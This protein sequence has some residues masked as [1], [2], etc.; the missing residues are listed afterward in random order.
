MMLHDTQEVQWSSL[1]PALTHFFW[2]LFLVPCRLE[3]LFR[4]SP[5][6]AE[7]STPFINHSKHHPPSP[8]MSPQSS[9]K[10]KGNDRI[11]TSPSPM[12]NSNNITNNFSPKDRSI[13]RTL[14]M[15]KNSVTSPHEKVFLHIWQ[16]KPLL[17]LKKTK[18]RSSQAS[19]Y[20]SDLI[21]S[22][23]KMFH[24]CI[25]VASTFLQTCFQI[26]VR[27][28][29]ELSRCCLS[30]T[31][32]D[33]SNEHDD[34][35]DD[36]A[37][38]NAGLISTTSECDESFRSLLLVLG[39]TTMTTSN[40]ASLLLALFAR[41][42]PL[43]FSSLTT[44]ILDQMFSIKPSSS[45]PPP[46]ASNT[47]QHHHHATLSSDSV[48]L[49]N[50][51]RFAALS[52]VVA[53]C[54]QNSSVLLS[55]LLIAI[56]KNLSLPSS[57][58]QS[59]SKTQT[60]KQASHHHYDMKSSPSSSSPLTVC[61]GTFILAGHLMTLSCLSRGDREAVIQWVGDA[62]MRTSEHSEEGSLE[63]TTAGHARIFLSLSLCVYIYISPPF[64]INC[65]YVI[66]VKHGIICYCFTSVGINCIY[67]IYVKHGIICYCFTSV[68]I[69]TCFYPSIYLSKIYR[70]S[71]LK[72]SFK[73]RI[74][75]CSAIGGQ[76][77]GAT[78]FL[79]QTLK[80]V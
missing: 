65:I 9:P 10:M 69:V 6:Y 23:A 59:T 19:L 66:Y 75:I 14:A 43:S 49:L 32:A 51:A 54:S 80:W 67:V 57:R 30:L 8:N 56:R 11:A 18:R 7:F 74:S 73:L 27:L 41:I 20:S 40:A 31:F 55:T 70:D 24:Y 68:G 34:D 76:C 58:D 35:D 28:R 37:N 29:E 62:C 5:M 64:H 16:F 50:S 36:D 4:S 25:S 72:N 53:R 26:H 2:W 38:N 39:S 52:E 21:S 46:H 79:V 13:L 63:I 42:D 60:Q 22:I 44:S 33:N 77:I 48:L 3:E 12:N 71:V 78:S 61:G 45:P 1:L 47:H 17:K 15:K